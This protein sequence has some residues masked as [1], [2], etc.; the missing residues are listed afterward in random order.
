VTPIILAFQRVFWGNI[1]EHTTLMISYTYATYLVLLAA[2]LGGS[3]VIFFL[4]MHV[5]G[6][7]AANF[8][9]EL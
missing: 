2:V 5:F 6:R 8:A 4:G 9:E 1:G 3:I 7:V